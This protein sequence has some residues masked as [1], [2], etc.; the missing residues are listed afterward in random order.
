MGLLAAF[1]LTFTGFNDTPL[2]KQILTERIQLLNHLGPVAKQHYCKSRSFHFLSAS[3]VICLLLFIHISLRGKKVGGAGCMR[4]WIYNGTGTMVETKQNCRNVCMQPP[5]QRHTN[6]T[7]RFP[8]SGLL[9][10]FPSSTA[11]YLH[12]SSFWL[13]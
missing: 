1:P 9:L 7:F 11:R 10:F 6:I 5:T 12:P 2:S 8:I 4:E 3:L 13:P